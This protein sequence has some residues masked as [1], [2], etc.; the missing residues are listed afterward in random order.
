MKLSTS[1]IQGLLLS[2]ISGSPNSDPNI[3]PVSTIEADNSIDKF[4][5]E[6]TSKYKLCFNANENVL[7]KDGSVKKCVSKWVSTSMGNAE[8]GTSFCSFWC[9]KMKNVDDCKTNKKKFNYHPDWSCDR[10]ATYC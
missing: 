8:H 2:V 10:D 9:S 4:T 1:L 5:T 7:C 6:A 3:S